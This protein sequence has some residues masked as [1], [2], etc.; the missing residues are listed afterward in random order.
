MLNSVMIAPTQRV[1]S[2]R[3]SL[4]F[5]LPVCPNAMS[6]PLYAVVGLCWPAGMLIPDESTLCPVGC[7][8]CPPQE[9][10]WITHHRRR[11]LIARLLPNPSPSYPLPWL[12]L[13]YPATA[14]DGDS[15]WTRRIAEMPSM[16][17]RSA[18]WVL[19]GGVGLSY[20][21]R[22][23]VL[24]WNWVFHHLRGALQVFW[25]WGGGGGRM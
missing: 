20:L 4:G 19:W 17:Q 12:P 5:R 21:N 9:A 24:T 10:C 25:W 2:G 13:C 23:A 18:V 22:G 1:A 14:P 3:R 11:R 7:L 16:P 8:I 15:S 6:S